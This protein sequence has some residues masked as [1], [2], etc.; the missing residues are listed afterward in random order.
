VIDPYKV[1]PST[2]FAPLAGRSIAARQARR[3]F[4]RVSICNAID[5]EDSEG[6]Q[7][8]VLLLQANSRDYN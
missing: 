5:V 1:A 3:R 7:L 6:Y 2:M 4:C 8:S